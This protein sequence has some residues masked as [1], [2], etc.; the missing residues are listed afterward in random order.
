MVRN[1][2]HFG[3]GTG[4]L[5]PCFCRGDEV[6]RLMGACCRSMPRTV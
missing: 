6:V 2:G 1:R 3:Y 4:Q 5:Y